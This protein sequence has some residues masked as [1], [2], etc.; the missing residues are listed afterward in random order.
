MGGNY[1]QSNATKTDI[2]TY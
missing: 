2:T 1:H